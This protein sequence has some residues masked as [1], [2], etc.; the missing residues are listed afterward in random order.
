MKTQNELEMNLQEIM[1]KINKCTKEMGKAIMNNNR[2]K[3]KVTTNEITQL[4]AKRQA[5]QWALS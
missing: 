3:I 2:E 4:D 1:S 5:L